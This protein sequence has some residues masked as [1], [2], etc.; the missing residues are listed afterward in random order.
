MNFMFGK[1]RRAQR[2]PEMQKRMRDA[3]RALERSK[4]AKRSTAM[5]RKPCSAKKTKR[6]ETTRKTER[7]PERATD[8]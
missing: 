3:H 5:Q 7:C 6:H 2:G 1:P 4:F 8:F